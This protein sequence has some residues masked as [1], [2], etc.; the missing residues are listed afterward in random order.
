MRNKA[1][2]VN[3]PGDGLRGLY[4]PSVC[5]E[6]CEVVGDVRASQSHA[7]DAMWESIALKN[8]DGV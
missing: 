4:A 7:L 1:T 5:E 2:T 6:L 3:H 8:G